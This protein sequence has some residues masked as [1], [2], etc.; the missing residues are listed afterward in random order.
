MRGDYWRRNELLHV[1]ERGMS[2]A[3]LAGSQMRNSQ[4][5]VWSAVSTRHNAFP[6]SD[7]N[8][9]IMVGPT[10]AKFDLEPSVWKESDAC[11][12]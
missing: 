4:S 2:G 1:R 7:R 3:Q 10:P 8:A 6:D 5:L 11:C 9:D 12:A